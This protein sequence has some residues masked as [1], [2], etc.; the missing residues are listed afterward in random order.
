MSE[1]FDFTVNSQ[2]V[3]NPDGTPLGDGSTMSFTFQVPPKI[4][5]DYKSVKMSCLDATIWN[6]SPNVFT[7]GTAKNN[8]FYVNYNGTNYQASLL[9]GQYDLNGLNASLNI[10]LTALNSAMAGLITFTP[11]NAANRVIMTINQANTL[12]S[13]NHNDTF[14]TLIGW[15]ANATVPSGGSATTGVYTEE[16]ANVARF[17]TVQAFQIN[18]TFCPGMPSSGANST[19]MA[20]IPITSAPGK[21]VVYSPYNPTILNA[22]KM[23]GGSGTYQVWLTDQNGNNLNT[24]GQFWQARFRLSVAR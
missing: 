9:Q 20:F 23:I 21:Q 11:D 13:F 19:V 17:D 8:S 4:P 5:P 12:V 10:A 16:A 3:A 15:T 14:S 2:S 1:T 24:G 6:T 18:S 7:S 22:S